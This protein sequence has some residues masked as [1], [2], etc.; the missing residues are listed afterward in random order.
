MQLGFAAPP[1]KKSNKALKAL[2][3]AEVHTFVQDF[4]GDDVHATRVR[5]LANGVLGV[6]H[7]AALRIHTIGRGLAD[8]V[9]LNP[10]HA[11]KQVDRLLSN[12]GFTVWDWFARWVPFVLAH[13]KR[14]VVALDWTEFQR[15]DHCT[16]TLYSVTSHG[17]A[18][19]VGLENR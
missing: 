12:E 15:D 9:G 2:G 16:I 13:R 4:I 18:T 11:I 14:V 8:A 6:L 17:R 7:S 10:K 19:A 3:P 1:S 5:S